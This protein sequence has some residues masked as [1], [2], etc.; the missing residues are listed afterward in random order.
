MAAIAVSVVV[1][2]QNGWLGFS[3]PSQNVNVENEN[4]ANLSEKELTVGSAS[5]SIASP[6]VNTDQK[7]ANP[8]N[9]PQSPNH[10]I[11]PSIQTAGFFPSRNVQSS[12]SQRDIFA[13]TNI[14]HHSSQGHQSLPN[15]NFN[16]PSVQSSR[17]PSHAGPVEIPDDLLQDSSI[18]PSASNV[19]VPQNTVKTHE[20][21]GQ[22]IQGTVS[23]VAISEGEHPN[24]YKPR[25]TVRLKEGIPPIPIHRVPIIIDGDNSS[26]QSHSINAQNIQNNNHEVLCVTFL[27]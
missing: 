25:Y 27:L 17:K 9:I 15:H 13:N 21:N 26:P 16:P 2:Y 20:T 14:N 22:N 7:L 3:S 11:A 1:C 23:S 8:S 18:N 5:N 19:N 4:L 6:K 12:G 10:P 24:N